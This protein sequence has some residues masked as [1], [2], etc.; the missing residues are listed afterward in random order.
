[1]APRTRWFATSVADPELQLCGPS[2]A[3]EKNATM[4]HAKEVGTLV[5][6]CGRHATTW[7]K[8]WT[9]FHSKC[10]DRLVVHPRSLRIGFDGIH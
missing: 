8:H 3:R 4:I 6:A 5:T 1:M 10:V 9:P 7:H 2:S